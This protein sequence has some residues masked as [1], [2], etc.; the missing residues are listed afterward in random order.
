MAAH[1]L[2]ALGPAYDSSG[3]V[4]WWRG[5]PPSAAPGATAPAA[6]PSCA[7]AQHPSPVG[8]DE[9]GCIG[10]ASRDTLNQGRVW[11]NSSPSLDW[12]RKLTRPSLPEKR[13]HWHEATTSK[14]TGI[15]ACCFPVSNRFIIQHPLAGQGAAA[16]Q[17]QA[18][19]QGLSVATPVGVKW[20][21]LRVT[22]VRPRSRAV[23]AISRSALS[24][25]SAAE[26]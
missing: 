4:L 3:V 15:N 19:C 23:A 12:T 25:P 21:R 16:A 6:W 17:S 2:S 5:A 9:G 1:D 22:T 13:F 24:C 11:I 18:A 7:A 8:S 26:S 10:A 14:A 20:R